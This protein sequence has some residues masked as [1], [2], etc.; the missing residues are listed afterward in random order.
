MASDTRATAA[1]PQLGDVEAA[2]SRVEP[3]IH[4]TPLLRSRLLSE[5]AGCN[6]LLKA[7]IFQK[8]GSYKIRGPLNKI[9]LLTEGERA[10]GVVCS[11]AGNHA[12][13]VAIAAS[14]H[15]V[16]AVVVMAENAT[17]AKV[18]ATRAY[19]AEVIQCG[20]IWDEANARA[21]EL[22]QERG[23]TFIHPF[24]DT[25]LIAAACPFINLRRSS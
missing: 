15:G 11:S 24:D 20:S 14:I 7:E 2:R 23:L 12:Q 16:R 21:H 13:G 22:A 9:P 5:V 8:G 18:A 1:L 6:V 17:P 25:Q 4:R 3:H 10:A 19:G